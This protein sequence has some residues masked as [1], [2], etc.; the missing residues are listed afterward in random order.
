MNIIKMGDILFNEFSYEAQKA[1]VDAKYEKKNLKHSYVGTEHLMLAILKRDNDITNEL[2]NYNVTYDVFKKAII[3]N[4]GMGDDN[5]NL[6]IY[7]PM[8]KKVLDYVSNIRDSEITVN[9][10]FSALLEED[11]VAVRIL[12]LLNV[13]IDKLYEKFIKLDVNSAKITLLNELGIDLNS[14][15]ECEK[16][17]PVI[18]R[19]KEINR[20]IEILCRRTKNN[21]IL[22]G[23]AGVGKTAIVE[24]L[25]DLIVSGNVPK[26][27]KNKKIISLDMASMVA[28][29]KY[30][31]EFEDRMKKVLSELENNSDIILFID[32][33]HTIMG[34]GGAEGAIDASNI[35]KPALARGK[36]RCI[37]ATTLD[38]Y[39][40]YIEV[41]S[42][43]NRRFQ[44]IDIIEPSVDLTKDILLNLKDVYADYH[45]VNISDEIVNDIVNL[46]HKYIKDRHEPDRSIDILDEVCSRASLKED[47]N[48]NKLKELNSKLK[49]TSRLKDKFIIN[50][51]YKKAYLYREKENKL[52]SKINC[53]ELKR[54]R[55]NNVLYDDIV[56]VIKSKIN[57][58]ILELNDTYISNIRSELMCKYNNIGIDELL[59]NYNEKV[60]IINGNSEDKLDI[61]KDYC[62]MVVGRNN[63]ITL[64]MS[65]YSESY[66]ISKIV[67]APPGYIGYDNNHSLFDEIR[68]K[69]NSILIL[70]NIE[71]CSKNIR[72]LFDDIISNGISK[73]SKGNNIDFSNV[74]F[75]MISNKNDKNSI[76]FNNKNDNKIECK[77]KVITFNKLLVVS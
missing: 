23:E 31:G 16:I 74:K 2:N 65:E 68:D 11:C 14:K 30:R 10:L 61:I 39:R 41:D 28:G 36:V 49:E 3:D 58:P 9:T 67:G 66:S 13:D 19:D 45:G 29:T 54:N 55:K 33:I 26:C 25:A 47:T 75:F 43:L 71:K 51:D 1:L 73:D 42:A 46:S 59:N 15:A 5:N 53:I 4:I 12:M 57:V 17:D 63:T 27:L 35:F 52:I 38:E 32:E 6:F 69:A 20:L 60:L 50:N 48:I 62:N 40:K 22:I 72:N 34:A 77:Y 8:L 56:D 24:S 64:D 70:N 21:P 18:G 7:T 44:R 37:G 76:G